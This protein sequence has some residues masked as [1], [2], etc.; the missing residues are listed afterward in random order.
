[1]GDEGLCSMPNIFLKI[2]IQSFA[3]AIPGSP[4]C[5]EE[6]IAKSVLVTYEGYRKR[7]MHPVVLLAD[8]LLNTMTPESLFPASPYKRTA[9]VSKEAYNRSTSR[10]PLITLNI[11]RLSNRFY[12]FGTRKAIKS[13]G[14]VVFLITST[15]LCHLL[16]GCL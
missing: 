16:R 7:R 5:H 2:S 14:T 10:R 8:Q 6:R 13:H 1:M 12:G 4:K 15:C 11:H 9:M 3:K